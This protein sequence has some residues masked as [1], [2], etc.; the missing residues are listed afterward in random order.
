METVGGGDVALGGAGGVD[1]GFGAGQ[2]GDAVLDPDGPAVE[3]NSSLEGVRTLRLLEDKDV[4]EEADD[5]F[6]E[7]ERDDAESKVLERRRIEFLVR[8]E[9]SADCPSTVRRRDGPV[10]G[11]PVG[12]ELLLAGPDDPA[13]VERGGVAGTDAEASAL[14]EREEDVWRTIGTRTERIARKG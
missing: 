7:E 14:L 1:D 2:A 3:G 11:P 8:R 9:W 5:G 13:E 10:T 6:A 12:D 4:L